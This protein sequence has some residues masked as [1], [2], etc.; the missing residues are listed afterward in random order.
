MLGARGWLLKDGYG[1]EDSIGLCGMLLLWRASHRT[2]RRYRESLAQLAIRRS[3]AEL[4]LRLIAKRGMAQEAGQTKL[5]SCDLA[6][7]PFLAG[8]WL[9][10][11]PQLKVTAQVAESARAKGEW[12]L[13]LCLSCIKMHAELRASLGPCFLARIP[14]EKKPLLSHAICRRNSCSEIT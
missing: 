2:A 5:A 8:P 7:E 6:A 12:R 10:L 9:R 3:S 14:C 4:T 1:G 11:R 13:T